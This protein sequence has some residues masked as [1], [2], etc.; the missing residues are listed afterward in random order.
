M[1]DFVWL[2]LVDDFIGDKLIVGDEMFGFIVCLN[3]GILC[4]YGC[5]LFKCVVD[6]D[7]IVG[8][9]WFVG[10]ECKVSDKVVY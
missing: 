10:D 7:Y 4:L 8:F 1:Y 5:Y 9:N 6:F 3:G 2:W